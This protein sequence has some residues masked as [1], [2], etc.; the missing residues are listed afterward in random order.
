MT[1]PGSARRV[2][3]ASVPGCQHVLSPAPCQDACAVKET[4]DYVVLAVSDG[5]GDAAYTCADE[6]ARTAVAVAV[7]ALSAV[8]AQLVKAPPSPEELDDLSRRLKRNV[9]AEWNRRVKHHA[10]MVAERDGKSFLW[11]AGVTGDWD[12][13]TKPYGCTL[14][15]VAIAPPRA[16]WF[17]L[18]DGDLLAVD[19]EKAQRVF[20]AADKSVGQATFSLSMR[21]CVDSMQVRFE[22][23]AHELYLL[24]SDGVGD[25][26]DVDPRFEEEWGTELLARIRTQGFVEVGLKLPRDLGTM[27]RDGDDCTVAMAWFPHIEG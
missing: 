5:H 21:D 20:P 27:A 16:V 6:G 17:Q 12:D 11:P 13:K 19:A 23:A 15:A 14:L 1:R 18:G 2:A 8:A 24:S 10:R 9:A 25:Q 3:A 4:E 7:E 22:D 26:Y